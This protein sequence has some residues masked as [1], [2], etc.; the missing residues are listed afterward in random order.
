MKSMIL[1][2][3]ATAHWYSLIQEAEQSCAIHLN[4][5]LENYLVLLLERFTQVTDFSN[6]VMGLEYLKSL[7]EVAAHRQLALR[8]I[9][10]QCLL[11]TGLFPGRAEKRHVRV[12]YFI[13]I[14]QNAY[15]Q[16]AQNSN[17]GLKILFNGLCEQ[18]I[19]VMDV[20]QAARELTD[21]TASL[22]PLLAEEIW[23][24]VNSAHAFK[25]LQHYSNAI[26]IDNKQ[27]KFDGK[28]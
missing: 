25:I 14:G 22:S 13:N 20:L 18:F 16:L 17:S 19:T 15:F 5:E 10:D 2:P 7:N 26:P 11:I 8:N 1:E 27:D 9:G 21:K 12:S 28:H 24:D 3:T 6:K 23:T 4:I